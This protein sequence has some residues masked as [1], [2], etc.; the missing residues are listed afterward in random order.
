[1]N[2]NQGNR[3][4]KVAASGCETFGHP[5]HFQIEVDLVDHYRGRLSV[6]R[7]IQ[8]NYL[9]CSNIINVNVEKAF[10]TGF[11]VIRFEDLW[12]VL[13]KDVLF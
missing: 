6:V 3:L 9:V 1:M 10:N 5:S 13:F 11:I 4:I 7:E 12:V 2:E 8:N